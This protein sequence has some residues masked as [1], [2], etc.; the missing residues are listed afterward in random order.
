M[1]TMKYLNGILLTALL[2][3]AVFSG[4][5]TTG[6]SAMQKKADE[7]FPRHEQATIEE[8]GFAPDAA[9]DIALIDDGED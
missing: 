8:G 3:I 2:V 4:C 6:E 9:W 5:A 1:K 7:L